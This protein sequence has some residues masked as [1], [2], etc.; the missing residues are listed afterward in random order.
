MY[1][2]SSGVDRPYG[3]SHFIFSRNLHADFH[4]DHTVFPPTLCKSTPF[5]VLIQHPFLFFI[6]AIL[7]GAGH[8]LLMILNYF[9]LVSDVE[10]F[11][12]HIY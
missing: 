7:S 5:S 2:P 4:S 1:T 10:H 3:N 9:S 11:F 6:I 8:S 12:P